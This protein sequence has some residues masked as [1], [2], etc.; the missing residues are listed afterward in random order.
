[1]AAMV[2]RGFWPAQRGVQLWPSAQQVA[3][4][5]RKQ[6][7]SCNTVLASLFRFR[8]CVCHGGVDAAA[9]CGCVPDE[10][11]LDI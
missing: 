5:R 4:P 10:I 11:P 6:A 8:N 1:M 2:V 3:G 7:I 9:L